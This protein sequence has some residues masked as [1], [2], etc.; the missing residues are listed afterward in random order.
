M[1]IHALET[2]GIIRGYQALIEKRVLGADITVFVRVTLERQ[3]SQAL[4]VFESAI[5]NCDCIASCYLMAGEYDYMLQVRVSSM[6]DYER[7]HKQE[8]SRFPGVSRLE[9]S[10]AVRDVMESE[11]DRNSRR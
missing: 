5:R 8:L 3:S 9:S 10:F 4:Q 2:R 1:R 11:I 7:V 6:A